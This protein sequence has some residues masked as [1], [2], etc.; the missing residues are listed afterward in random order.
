VAY[1][2]DY[3]GPVMWVPSS[4][5]VQLGDR[6]VPAMVWVT[7]G[8][9]ISGDPM[10]RLR[11]E[12]VGDR[13]QCREVHFISGTTGRELRQSDLDGL[14]LS[15]WV[16]R[17]FATAAWPD[18]VTTEEFRDAEPQLRKAVSTARRGR[19]ARKL[20]REFL[21]QVA[22]V[23]RRNVDDRP[24]QTVSEAFGISHSTA[25][26]YVRRARAAGLLPPTTPGK[27]KA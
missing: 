16:E 7:I 10:V 27:R 21:E 11:L 18:F 12:V 13:P 26:E 1:G 20:N 6:T 3:S 15:D 2:G 14:R 25:A 8:D 4:E 22:E 5:T 24:T 19:P 9:P 17:M 23:Y